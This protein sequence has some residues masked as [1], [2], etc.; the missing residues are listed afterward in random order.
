MTPPA[1]RSADWA[2]IQLVVFDVDGTLYSQRRLRLHMAPSLL[3]RAIA[4][5]DPKFI[6]VLR[7]YRR[8]REQL[9]DEEAPG[10]EAAAI[11]QTSA[12]E[13]CPADTVRTIVAEWIG[14]KPLPYLPRCIYPGV[15]GLFAALRRNNKT[16]GILSDYPARAKLAALGLAADLVVSAGD[17]GIGFLKPHPCGLEFLLSAAGVEPSAA[18]L[19]GDRAERDGLAAARAGVRALIRSPV[20]LGGCQTFARFDAPLF[21]PLLA[22]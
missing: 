12:L 10:F 5:R 17:E 14:Q 11:A 16:V 1:F 15:T 6:A 19:I 22:T 3:R 20:P 18:V 21:A 13:G 9:A 2:A 8:V 7:T 4:K